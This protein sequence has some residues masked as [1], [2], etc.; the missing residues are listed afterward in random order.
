MYIHPLGLIVKPVCDILKKDISYT[1]M[2]MYN[3]FQFTVESVMC[4]SIVLFY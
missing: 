2:H 1:S 3:E 4:T